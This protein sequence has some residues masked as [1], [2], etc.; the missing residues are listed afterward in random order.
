MEAK[1]AFLIKFGKHLKKIRNAK[2]L[3]IREIELNNDI[4]RSFWSQVE[5]GNVNFTFY[6]LKKIADSLEVTIEELFK[7]FK[8]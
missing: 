2:G 1:K 7:G 8:Y 4:S 6:N 5:S 3:S